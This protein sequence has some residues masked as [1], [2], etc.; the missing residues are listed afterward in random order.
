MNKLWCCIGLLTGLQ[1]QAVSVS[2]NGVGEV[3]VVPYFTAAEGMNTYVT[4]TNTTEVTKVVKMKFLDGRSEFPMKTFNL[5][6]TPRD[7]FAFATGQVTVDAQGIQ[8]TEGGIYFNDD[9]CVVEVYS[10]APFDNRPVFA[11]GTNIFTTEGSIQIFEM[12]EKLTSQ[13]PCGRS[14]GAAG[15][16]DNHFNSTSSLRPPTGGLKATASII[17]VANGFQFSYKPVAFTDFYPDDEQHHYSVP[18]ANEPAL[19]DAGRVSAGVTYDS[20]I[21]A[22]GA[23]IISSQISNDFNVEPAVAAQTEWILTIPGKDDLRLGP[24]GCFQ[25]SVAR[26]Y[27]RK[28]QVVD[29]VDGQSTL[30]STEL[31]FCQSLHVLRFGDLTRPA[32]LD[33]I[34]ETDFTSDFEINTGE[35]LVSGQLELDFA[36]PDN[37]KLFSLTGLTDQGT[38]VLSGVPMIGFAVQKFNNGAAR[39]GLLAAYATA[40]THTFSKP[41]EG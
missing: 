35:A 29:L 39:P 18:S 4:V 40:Y 3:I 20:G 16:T 37:P 21:E 28:G 17:D 12:A 23:A 10:G 24:A 27:N 13:T 26:L 9:S 15:S 30:T 36:Q 7:T 25:A 34:Y 2:P 32:I 11:P 19:T 5:Y 14:E 8:L 33:S 6:L 22:F 31:D 41:N 38:T 1:A